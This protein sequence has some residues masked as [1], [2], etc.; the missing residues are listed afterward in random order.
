MVFRSR[1]RS[2]LLNPGIKLNAS[3]VFVLSKLL[4]YAFFALV[5]L[6]ILTPFL[7]LWYS[8]DLPAPGSL[9]VSKYKDATRIYD[10]KGVLLYSVYQD[11]N[12]TYVKLDEIPKYLEEGTIAIEDKDFYQNKGFS[13]FAYLRVVKNALLG[14]G[15]AGG[16]TISQQLVKNVLLTNERRLSRKIKEL[17]LSIQVNQTY[18]KDQ[19]LEMY[20]NNIPYG[21]SAIGVEAASEMY[22]G[23]KV[24][25]LDLA[26][27]AF[28]AGL[29]Q[30]PSIY[31]PFSGNKY[32]VNRTDAVLKR[33]VEDKYITKEQKEAAL[34]KI[35]N[36]SFKKENTTGIKAPH[37]VMYVKQALGRQFTDAMVATGGLQ[38]TTSLDYD[39]QKKAEE[40][41]K[42]E[43]DKL[44]VH[45]VSNGAAV[46]ADPKTGEIL[47]MVG[48][49][50]YFD[51]ENDGNYNVAIKNP[52]S[53][54]RQPGSSM[55]PIMYAAALEKGYKAST[56]IMDTKTEFPTLDPKEPIYTPE[57]Y[58]GNYNGPVQ[59][60][61]ALGNS[62][63]IPA[64]KLL[65]QVG[66]EPV[67]K[68]AYE[69]GINNWQPTKENMDNVGLSL[70]LG[71][72]E[73]T[74]LDE[75]TAYSVLANK[76]VKQDPVSILKVTDKDGHTLYEHKKINGKKVLSE[77]V[78]FIISHILLD[79]NA[80]ILAFGP[81]SYL[82]IP[83]KTVS[84]KTGT[85]D[86]KRD[87]W[88]FG[89]TPSYVVGVWVGNNDNTPMNQA[90]ASGITGAS[91]I[92][93]KI[94]SYVLKGKSDEQLQKPDNVVALEIDAF[95]GGLP[96]GGQ[97]V[98]SE[99][100][101]KGTEPTSEAPIYK[102]KDGKDY[103][104]FR[105]D[106]PVSTDGQNRW[107]KGID[108]WINQKYPNDEKYHPPG[109]IIN[110]KKE[111]PTPTPA[112]QAAETTPASQ[113]GGPT[114]APTPTP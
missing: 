40:I 53:P 36:Y 15:L 87:N 35:K 84:V 52:D 62:L 82:N 89:Y 93:N 83:G 3:Q 61:F 76:G 63:N 18:T 91:P 31:S 68:K 104:L 43:V 78:A 92:W 33:M 81:N 109:E 37:F 5:G 19:I 17:I 41:V 85:T 95:G 72:R 20:L 106:D 80:R 38:V 56:L 88:T 98:R 50:D 96:H 42:T 112:V 27:S 77:E 25:D 64:V 60:R 28:L 86:K 111:E 30:S 65:A 102:S 97:S 11:E 4:K 101:I 113:Q 54:G 75:V 58:D 1:R 94:M 47:A 74:L 55:K 99:Y 49:K 7:F 2:R 9:V 12:R 103:L 44:K 79:N 8:R 21:G 24:K 16:S 13:P 100:F 67:M 59:V 114:D 46:V 34:S 66:V 26:E 110:P 10:R 22:F 105:E 57:N 48:S 23:K 14:Q 69:M 32:Y 108:D 39:I 45:K 73:T 70:V 29:P 90:I 51:I 6:I 107:Q 71:G